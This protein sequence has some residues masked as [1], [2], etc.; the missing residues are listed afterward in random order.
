MSG[1]C[2]FSTLFFAALVFQVTYGRQMCLSCQYQY[3]QE[4][5]W[6]C[7][8]D[9]WNWKNS[10]NRMRCNNQCTFQFRQNTDT[11]QITFS[12]RGC[13]GSDWLVENGCIENKA[14]KENSCYYNCEGVD[15]CNIWNTTDILTESSSAQSSTRWSTRDLPMSLSFGVLAAMVLHSY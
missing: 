10:N 7:N 2:I 3:N 12:H 15:Y 5:G 8:N 6:P 11:G 1:R 9:P 13:S 4:S 14:S